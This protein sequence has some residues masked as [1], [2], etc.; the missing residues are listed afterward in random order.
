MSLRRHH[1]QQFWIKIQTM[2][3]IC[4]THKIIYF[5]G[6]KQSVCFHVTNILSQCTWCSSYSSM[7]SFSKNIH[8]VARQMSSDDTWFVYVLVTLIARFYPYWIDMSQISVFVGFMFDWLIHHSAI[9]FRYPST[10]VPWSWML[11]IHNS[12][13]TAPWLCWLMWLCI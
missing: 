12:P 1:L 3:L 6:Q 9:L 11:L 2:I 13:D 7:A 5:C 8:L 4:H 10:D